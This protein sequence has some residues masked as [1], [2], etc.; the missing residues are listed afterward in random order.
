M[1]GP[2]VVQKF[3]SSVLSDRDRL[4]AVVHDVYRA[5]RRGYQVVVVVSAIGRHTDVLLAEAHHIANPAAPAA[6]LAQL[7]ATGDTQSA[8]LLTLSL[9]RAG[10][11]ASIL[12]TASIDF[13]AGG[14]RLDAEPVSV[15]VG[16]LRAALAETPVVVVPGFMARHE[17]GGIAVLGRGGSDLTAVFLAAS[18]GA[19]QCRL[20]K[21]VDGIYERD[22]AE[23]AADNVEDPERI[24]G[25]GNKG[26]HRYGAITYDEALRVAA[27][28]VQPKA[29]EYL[30]E[31]GCTAEVTGLLR[32]T[33]TV[34]GAPASVVADAAS[35]T[36]LRVI[37]L[38]FSVTGGDV[39]KCLRRLPP[40]FDVIGIGVRKAYQNK[41]DGVDPELFETDIEAL[42]ARPHDVLFEVGGDAQFHKLVLDSELSRGIAVVT[43]NTDLVVHHGMELT[44]VAAANKTSFAYTGAAGAAASMLE[45]VRRIRRARR[46]QKIRGVL[47]GTCCYVLDELTA[48]TALADA[49]GQAQAQGL[50]GENPDHELSGRDAEDKLR[51]LAQAVFEEQ[52]VSV[53]RV[54][55]GTLSDDDIEAAKANGH[56]LRQVAVLDADGRA[57]VAPEAL[58]ADDFLAGAHSEECRLELIAEDGRVDRVRGNGAG[59]WPTAEAVV[60]D[61]IDLHSAVS[62]AAFADDDGRYSRPDTACDPVEV[63]PQSRDEL[64]NGADR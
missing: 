11:P 47:N 58:P 24:D 59:R 34:V 48:G 46:I 21:D 41:D 10:M 54:A 40:L 14:D 63:L 53:R 12:D 38:G 52:S 18:L 13:V 28:L 3:G 50:A 60:A 15:N 25:D 55:L 6:A 49:V 17:Q 5:Y 62:A 51:L 16:V 30:R 20:V 32:D 33:G 45:A 29:V 42:I 9:R 56:T 4:P 7:V 8:A 19:R 22:P 26:P 1:Q 2:L 27:V 44:A 57:S 36:P 64:S 23:C 39:V 31:N 43:A 37:V 35:F 61:L